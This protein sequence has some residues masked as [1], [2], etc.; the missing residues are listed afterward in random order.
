MQLHR[1]LQALIMLLTT[2]SH[3]ALAEKLAIDPASFRPVSLAY[4]A[5]KLFISART[6]VTLNART[7]A[8]VAADLFP[9]PERAA[10]TPRGEQV[11]V[12]SLKTQ[13]L[14]RDSDV[15]AW[16]NPDGTLLQMSAINSGHKDRYRRYTYETD[17]VYSLKRYPVNDTERSQG[18]TSWSR[19]EEDLYAIEPAHQGLALTE[20][21]A[22]FYL[23]SVIDWSQAS[24]TR[25]VILFDPDGLIRLT[26]R[27][28][29]EDRVKADFRETIGTES[30]DVDGEIVVQRVRMDAAPL[31]P[32][33]GPQDFDFLGYKGGVDLYIDPQ[34]HAILQLKGRYDYL[35]EVIIRLDR[36][37]R[38]AP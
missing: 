11:I 24:G 22:L 4:H 21:E 26:L 5:S 18:W 27:F 34:R 19:S 12:Q 20:A 8:E 29:G 13:V 33:R 32:G 7:S 17:Q 15:T 23:V 10:P 36:L 38:P 30:R 31:E 35:G 25:E 28:D 6:Q 37:E 14:G 9:A 1:P 16:I 2:L 3:A